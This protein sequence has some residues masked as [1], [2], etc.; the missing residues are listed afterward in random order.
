MRVLH[1]HIRTHGAPAALYSDRHSIFHINA[2]DA[3]AE[4]ETRFARAACELG[5]ECIPANTP[6]AKGRV[7]RANQTLQDRLVKEMRLAGINDMHSA[8]AWLPG[9]IA[10]YSRRF[11]VAPKNTA[12]AHLAN[13]GTAEELVRTLSVQVTRALSQNL[14][15]HHENQ[16]LQIETTGAGLGLRRAK[17]TVHEH[18]DGRCKLLWKKRKLTYSVME[19]PRRQIPV[20]DSKIIN[21]RVDKAVTQHNMEQKPVL[22]HPWR[23]MPIGKSAND[24]RCT[25]L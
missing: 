1:D 20:A 4:A 12:D 16:L 5:I 17:V 23:G 8:N 19:K 13:P 9:Y 3:N 24:E 22:N 25:T 7:E 21:A 6:Q 18:F 11:A 2:K 14:S 10:D 15:C